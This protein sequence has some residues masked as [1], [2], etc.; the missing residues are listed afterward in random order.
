MYE[1]LV[2]FAILDKCLNTLRYIHFN[3][4]YFKNF[5]YVTN[6]PKSSSSF[7]IK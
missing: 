7:K 3:L 5:N 4:F 1:F 2:P 6:L